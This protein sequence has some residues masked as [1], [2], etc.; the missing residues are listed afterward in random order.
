MPLLHEGQYCMRK[1]YD[2]AKIQFVGAIP[3]VNCRFQKLLR[4][5]TARIGDADVDTPELTVN[6]LGELTN[7][8]VFRNVDCVRVNG[9]TMQPLRFLRNLIQGVTIACAE[10]EVSA[11]GGKCQRSGPAYSFAG[12][13]HDGNAIAKTSF[14]R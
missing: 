9:H 12:C 6:L 5:R 3:L 7:A 14:H 2:A 8:K 13:S 10:S 4:G 1:R 11:F